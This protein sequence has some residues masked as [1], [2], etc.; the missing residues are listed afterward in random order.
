MAFNKIL[1]GDM[2][3]KVLNGLPRILWSDWLKYSVV[4]GLTYLITKAFGC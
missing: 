1:G 2:I 3:K 4:I